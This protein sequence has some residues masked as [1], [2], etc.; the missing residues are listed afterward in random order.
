LALP[1]QQSTEL[2][3]QITHPARGALV[4]EHL[5]SAP[6]TLAKLSLI[7]RKF[8]PTRR[9]MRI[10]F[11]RAYR[12]RAWLLAGYLWRPV[13]LLLKSGPALIAWRRARRE[14]R[15]GTR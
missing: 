12:G 3:L 11:P 2:L 9:F 5:A 7:A 4:L 8:V 14:T 10:W 1:V 6:G 13:W 15:A